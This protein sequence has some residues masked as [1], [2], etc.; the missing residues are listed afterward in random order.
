MKHFLLL[1]ISIVSL[2]TFAQDAASYEK[3]TTSFQ[4][5]FNAQNVD[6]IFDMYAPEMQEG[7]TKEGVTRFVQGCFKQ[8]GNLKS[9]T[10]VK[11]EGPV[12]SYS[13]TFDNA[14]LSMELLLSENGKISSLQFQE[15]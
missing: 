11:T 3:V 9:L 13:A 6:A 12:Y 15:L 8:F 1:L 2:S 10:F 7:M 14:N 5:Q 4:E